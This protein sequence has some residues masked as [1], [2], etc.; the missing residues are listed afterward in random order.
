MSRFKHGDLVLNKWAGKDNPIRVSVFIRS[1][2]EHTYCVALDGAGK[3]TEVRYYTSDIE[4][5][6]DKFVKIGRTDAYAL[7]KA[8][9]LKAMGYKEADNG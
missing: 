1:G 7:L 4:K 5:Q 3:F 8:D 6:I 2:K 9:L